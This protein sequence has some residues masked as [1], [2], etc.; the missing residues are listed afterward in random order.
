VSEI[1]L[2][3][4]RFSSELREMT[5]TAI[6]RSV[7]NDGLAAYVAKGTVFKDYL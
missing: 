1:Q 5:F 3:V 6:S 2:D 4:L 7:K